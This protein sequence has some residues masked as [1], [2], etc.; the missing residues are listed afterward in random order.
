M[1]LN[2][3][4]V[5][6]FEEPDG[7]NAIDGRDPMTGINATEG[8]D[9]VT[10]VF[11]K[12]YQGGSRA[13]RKRGSRAKLGEK[14]FAAL[15]ADFEE[16]GVGAIARVRFLRPDV[17]LQ[18]L[19]KLMPQK[20]EI[21][22]PTDGMTDEQLE[23]MLAYAE[24][25]MAEM[26]TIEGVAVDVTPTALPAPR[27]GDAAGGVAVTIETLATP[28]SRHPSRD[29]AVAARRADLH[30]QHDAA[31]AGEPARP[32]QSLPYPV[33]RVVPPSDREAERRN[34]AKLTDDGDDIDPASLF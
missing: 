10:G 28:P 20:I 24:A 14:F 2:D 11:L 25:R 23:Q 9:A 30:D 18:V 5:K 17:Y 29:A 4:V 27:S 8:R 32:S 6:A 19:A 16:H 22:T 21:T 15:Q 26:K 31:A 33:G 12:G 34:V 13:G 1:K 3:P 7:R